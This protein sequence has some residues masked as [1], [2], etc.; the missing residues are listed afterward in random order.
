MPCCASTGFQT[1]PLNR[2][3]S[4]AT[5]TSKSLIVVFYVHQISA[6]NDTLLKSKKGYPVI[7]DKNE[8]SVSYPPRQ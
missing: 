2:E 3:S 7:P 5:R 1:T 4:P 8:S 6:N